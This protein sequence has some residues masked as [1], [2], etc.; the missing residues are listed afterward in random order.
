[1]PNDLS[2]FRL[3][4]ELRYRRLESREVLAK[5]KGSCDMPSFADITLHAPD[6]TLQPL[7]DLGDKPI[8]L[9]VLRYYG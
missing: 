9:Q 1:M 3:P 4:K 8:L 7:S 2:R 5:A 6:G